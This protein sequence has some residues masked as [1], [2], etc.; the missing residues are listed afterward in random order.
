MR[1]FLQQGF[2]FF[3]QESGI[4]GWIRQYE[5]V[6]FWCLAAVMI[7]SCLAGFWCYRLFFSMVVF[8]GIV[9]LWSAVFTRFIDWRTAAATFSVVGVA[10]ALL[11]YRWHR[12]GAVIICGLIAAGLAWKVHLSV[13][14]IVLSSV[15][16]GIISLGFPVAALCVMTAWGGSVLGAEL[17]PHILS[18]VWQAVF[19]A[20]GLAV[21]GLTARK[22]TFFMKTCPGWFHNWLEQRERKT[23]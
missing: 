10:A 15:S 8:M 21:Q 1:E 5:E 12:L 18:G 23:Q 20:A 7:V 17:F 3:A 2:A 4:I 6:G 16:A 19:F 9:T 14:L 11:A 22:Q 13:G